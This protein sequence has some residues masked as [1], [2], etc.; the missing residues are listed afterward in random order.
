MIAVRGSFHTGAAAS[1][2][3][4]IGIKRSGNQATKRSWVL[5]GVDG[6]VD[7]ERALRRVVEISRLSGAEICPVF[8]EEPL[9]ALDVMVHGAPGAQSG[10]LAKD[11]AERHRSVQEQVRR[12]AEET[13][14]EIAP[15]VIVRGRPADVIVRLAC[16]LDCDLIVLGR[17][18]GGL[19]HR[20]RPG[21]T[22]HAIL[23]HASCP[24]MVVPEVGSSMNPETTVEPRAWQ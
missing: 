3:R 16:E 10:A 4:R 22:T 7:A 21:S 18:G 17:R 8:A 13:A 20:L 24:V 2:K 19:G 6:S 1:G 9:G 12:V 11:I 15:P 5:V 23:A 14:V